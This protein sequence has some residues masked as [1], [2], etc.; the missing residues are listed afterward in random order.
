M[1]RS[2]R[3]G[4]DEYFQFVI[5]KAKMQAEQTISMEAEGDPSTFNMS[6]QV[7]RPESGEMIKFIQYA[8]ADDTLGDW[9]NNPETPDTIKA[10]ALTHTDDKPVSDGWTSTPKREKKTSNG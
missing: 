4:E 5:P 2:E 10:P 3:N 9:D 8:F 7:L 1:I 6:L